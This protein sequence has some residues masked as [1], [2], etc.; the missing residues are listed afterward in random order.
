MFNLTVVVF[1]ICVVPPVLLGNWYWS[2]ITAAIRESGR[3]YPRFGGHLLVILR[4]REVL[5]AETD[6]QRRTH[7]A[8]IGRRCLLSSLPILGWVAYLIVV[9]TTRL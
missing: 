4:Y 9:A 6:P 1:V 8:S 7:L 3:D 5:E 2:Q